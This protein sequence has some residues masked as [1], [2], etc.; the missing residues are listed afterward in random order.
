MSRSRK[1]FIAGVIP[2]LMLAALFMGY[3]MV[4]ALLNKEQGAAG[5]RGR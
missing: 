5:R 1:L 4:W 3:I 2:G